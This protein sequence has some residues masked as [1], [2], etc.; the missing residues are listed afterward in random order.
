MVAETVKSYVKQADQ[1]KW[2]LSRDPGWG[3]GVRHVRIWGRN[4]AKGENRVC[5]GPK[6]G[7]CLAGLSNSLETSM[8]RA[9]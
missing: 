6:A 3:E 1:I 7:M 5:K 8:T 2:C 9:E 4:I